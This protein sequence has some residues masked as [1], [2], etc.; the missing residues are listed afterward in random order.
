MQVCTTEKRK[1][2]I[3]FCCDPISFWKIVGAIVVNHGK[4]L[5]IFGGLKANKKF[6]RFFVV[7]AWCQVYN[8]IYRVKTRLH[9]LLQQDREFT[10]EDR[11]QINPGN[12]LSIN[13]AL[14]FVKNP[15]KCCQHVQAL[16][17][18]LMDIVRIKKDDPK[19]KG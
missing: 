5:K 2:F 8:F 16:I 6:I 4:T 13:D 1:E 15:V 3:Y 9:E 11:E 12:A 18:K 10:K 19:T 7:R 17:Q 14:D